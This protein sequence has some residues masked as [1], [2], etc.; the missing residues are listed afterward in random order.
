MSVA[1]EHGDVGDRAGGFVDDAAAD[2]KGD[3]DDA[4]IEEVGD[5]MVA[6]GERGVDL[7]ERE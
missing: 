1:E 2:T 7:S 5:R 6:D 3:V 4:D